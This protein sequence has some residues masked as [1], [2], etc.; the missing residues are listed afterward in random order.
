MR[1]DAEHI[2]GN[3]EPLS[4]IHMYVYSLY[5]LNVR[6]LDTE[7]LDGDNFEFIDHRIMDHRITLFGRHPQGLSVPTDQFI[8]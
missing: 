2:R 4:C 3:H 5:I 6:S 8:R 7:E 1:T